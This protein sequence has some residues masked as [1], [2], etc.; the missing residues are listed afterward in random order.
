MS[1]EDEVKSLI[2]KATWRAMVSNHE[3]CGA[4]LPH[5]DYVNEF[6]ESISDQV[7]T[8]IWEYIKD[9]D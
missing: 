9:F 8:D 7:Y 3:R 2:E 6:L 5:D 1:T 4:R